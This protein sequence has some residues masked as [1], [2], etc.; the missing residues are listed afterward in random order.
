M[1]YGPHMDTDVGPDTTV[2]QG[3]R[4]ERHSDTVCCFETLHLPGALP[5]DQDAGSADAVYTSGLTRPKVLRLRG[6]GNLR[7]LLL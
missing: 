4:R 3:V 5:A 7:A 6:L 1:R 2:R